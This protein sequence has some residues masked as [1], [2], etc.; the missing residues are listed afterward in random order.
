MPGSQLDAVSCSLPKSTAAANVDASLPGITTSR[1]HS[2]L[3]LQLIK[4]LHTAI[5]GSSL[6]F[7]TSPATLKAPSSVPCCLASRVLSQRPQ[8]WLSTQISWALLSHPAST[9][10][11]RFLKCKLFH[12]HQQ[13]CQFLRLRSLSD[14][15]ISRILPPQPFFPAIE[16]TDITDAP[17]CHNRKYFPVCTSSKTTSTMAQL[18][19]LPLF[20]N[21]SSVYDFWARCGFSA[22]RAPVTT[23][24]ASHL[25]RPHQQHRR[26]RRRASQ[27]YRVLAVISDNTKAT[28]AFHTVSSASRS[29]CRSSRAALAACKASRLTT[30]IYP[31][32]PLLVTCTRCPPRHL[33][34]L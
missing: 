9:W 20:A 31:A 13:R 4:H 19:V 30:Y 2:A 24:L 8:L 28:N 1:S 6:T 12:F 7:E 22:M 21:M 25:I 27:S 16:R 26:H 23:S 29:R 17:T 15:R 14:S 34:P 3:G 10:T 33:Q 11:S 18:S 32:S 5:A